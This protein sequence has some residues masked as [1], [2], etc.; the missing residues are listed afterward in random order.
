[1]CYYKQGNALLFAL[2]TEATFCIIRNAVTFHTATETTT[3]AHSRVLS[4]T[5]AKLSQNSDLT[6]APGRGMT[7]DT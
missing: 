6:E 4:P 2:Q 3:I 1:V 7:A 5:M